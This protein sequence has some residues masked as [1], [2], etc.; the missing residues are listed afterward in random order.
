MCRGKNWSHENKNKISGYDPEYSGLHFS[1]GVLT[2]ILLSEQPFIQSTRAVKPEGALQI[3]GTHFWTWSLYYVNKNV[4]IF[5]SIFILLSLVPLSFSKGQG[6]TFSKR[7]CK[8][9]KYLLSF[10]AQTTSLVAFLL[11]KEDFLN[12]VS[13]RVSMRPLREDRVKAFCTSWPIS[14]KTRWSWESVVKLQ[15]S[16]H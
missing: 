15:P 11:C 3:Q 16:L 12:S 2:S 10:D 6:G 9:C 1:N 5:H 4:D 14:F 7:T 8:E 13:T